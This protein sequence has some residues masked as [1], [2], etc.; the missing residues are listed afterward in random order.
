MIV[1]RQIVDMIGMPSMLGNVATGNGDSGAK[2]DDLD[3]KPS[4]LDHFVVDED[5]TDVGNPGVDDLAIFIDEAGFDHERPNFGEDF[6]VE[7]F[8]G[9]SEPPLGPGVDVAE[10]EIDDGAGG[11]GNAIED[12]EVI[13]SAFG[14]GEEPSVVC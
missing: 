2:S 3:V 7:C 9:H 6:A 1:M 10:S 12:V 13:Q 14:G 5:F 4:S 8:A 11:T